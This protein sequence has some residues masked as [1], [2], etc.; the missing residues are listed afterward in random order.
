[1]GTRLEA[2]MEQLRVRLVERM[3]EHGIGEEETPK[4]LIYHYTTAA[5]LRGIFDGGHIFATHSKYLN[6]LSEM[7]YGEDLC[8]RVIRAEFEQLASHIKSA[9]CVSGAPT[10]ERRMEDSGEIDPDK[11]RS[12]CVLARAIEAMDIW[13]R[14]DNY[15]TSFCQSGDLLSQWRGY[16]NRGGGYAIGMSINSSRITADAGTFGAV[17]VVY[18]RDEQEAVLRALLWDVLAGADSYAS[19]EINGEDT[20]ESI[21]RH[22]LRLAGFFKLISPRFKD[23][24]F[25]EENEWRFITQMDAGR[26]DGVHF[27]DTGGVVVPFIKL[28]ITVDGISVK[29]VVCGPTLLPELARHSVEMLLRKNGFNDIQIV[30]SRIP[31]GAF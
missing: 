31:L 16:A 1:M 20:R 22:G 6:D 30:S 25:G 17:R 3:E 12:R 5:G 15:I 13:P 2:H 29:R 23:A 19:G 28:P 9:P 27:R 7:R 11:G 26:V 14:K 24:A 21:S 8:K 18:K 10:L 4:D